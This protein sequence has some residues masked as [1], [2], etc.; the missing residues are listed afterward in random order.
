MAKKK[1]RIATKVHRDKTGESELPQRST[2][3]IVEKHSKVDIDVPQQREAMK[4]LGKNEQGKE[5]FDFVLKGMTKPH[6]K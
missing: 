4:S 5:L 1:K 3:D 6:K 2:K